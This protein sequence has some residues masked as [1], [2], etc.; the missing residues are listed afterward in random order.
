MTTTATTFATTF[1]D[2]TGLE[3]VLSRGDL[4]KVD[5]QTCRIFEIKDDSMIIC[6]THYYGYSVVNIADYLSPANIRLHLI[7]KCD[8]V[9]I[10]PDLTEIWYNLPIESDTTLDTILESESE[11]ESES[12]F[13]TE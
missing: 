8:N 7:S 10:G 5:D 1:A 6:W 4:L 3:C 13:D 2:F 12:E 11:S 9:L